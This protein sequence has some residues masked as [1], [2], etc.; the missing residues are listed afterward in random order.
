MSAAAFIFTI[1]RFTVKSSSLSRILLLQFPAIFWLQFP[2]TFSLLL[3]F[4]G[5]NEVDLS[6]GCD[7]EEELV[8]VLK[9][10]PGTT[11][12]TKFS[13][14][15]KIC[16]PFLVRRGSRTPLVSV[17]V[18]FAK[19]A[20]GQYGRSVFEQLHNNETMKITH[21]DLCSPIRRDFTPLAVTSVK[22][23]LDLL[24]V[25][26]SHDFKSISLN[27]CME[28]PESMTS[29]CSSGFS[30]RMPALPKHRQSFHCLGTHTTHLDIIFQYG[31]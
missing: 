10:S 30:R 16:F 4:A 6:C 20:K 2:S 22:K 28:A 12:G 14:L 15:Q 7:V 27:I 25:S 18:F 26:N 24:R 21:I 1:S 13:V 31:H 11:K 5:S 8:L 29:C 3:G 9:D 19:L 23:D 17:T